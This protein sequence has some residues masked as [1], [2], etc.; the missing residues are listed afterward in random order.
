MT[1]LFLKS[2]EVLE[3]KH[4]RIFT[5]HC[6]CFVCMRT[7]EENGF[8]NKAIVLLKIAWTVCMEAGLALSI[9]VDSVLEQMPG[10]V[11]LRPT[12]TEEVSEG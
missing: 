1:L 8:A 6:Q 4:S 10:S 7:S 12:S 3:T 2:Y 9:H 11:I 5:F